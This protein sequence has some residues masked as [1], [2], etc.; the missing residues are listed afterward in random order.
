MTATDFVSLRELNQHAGRVVAEVRGGREKII[1][2]HGP[3]VAKIVP[4]EYS[5]SSLNRLVALGLA[6]VPSEAV[7]LP[8]LAFLPP[9][10]ST[11][12]LLTED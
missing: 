10:L 6:S 3:P 1:T 9:G 4:L 5:P 7:Q 2:D 11:R 12:D 8:K